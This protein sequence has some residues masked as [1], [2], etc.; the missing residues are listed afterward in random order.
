MSDL[1]PTLQPFKSISPSR[2]FG[3]E[4]CVLREA[5][6]ANRVSQLLPSSP[7]KFLG[8]VSHSLIEASSRG[9]IEAGPVPAALR[10][11]ELVASQE[12]SITGP[13]ERHLVPLKKSSGRYHIIRAKTLRAAARAYRPRPVTPRPTRPGFGFEIRITTPDGALSGIVDSATEEAGAIVIRDYKSGSIFLDKSEETKPEYI[14]QLQLY[15]VIYWEEFGIWPTSLQLVPL[16]GEP[17]AIEVNPE[18]CQ[19]LA[20]AARNRMAAANRQIATV[21]ETRS[22][23]EDLATPSP[24]TCRYCQYRPLCKRYA[25]RRSDSPTL[26][27][28][29]DIWGVVQSVHEAPDRRFV[30]CVTQEAD[31]TVITVRRVSGGG[32]HINFDAIIPGARLGIFDLRKENAPNTYREGARTTVHLV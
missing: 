21:V 29:I 13:I 20:A 2:Y 17:V 15:A 22:R 16:V 24:P 7:A 27:W 3:L 12:A 23:L 30:I 1:L 8:E 10:W 14:T 4:K 5:L 9:S 18:E 28:P 31:G 26:E 6:S 11:D 25:D 32:R 19:T